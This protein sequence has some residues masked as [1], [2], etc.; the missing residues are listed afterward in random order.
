[1]GRQGLHALILHFGSIALLPNRR[2]TPLLDADESLLKH[3][4]FQRLLYPTSHVTER[5]RCQAGY[6]SAGA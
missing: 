1:M 6:V 2:F 5:R 3:V 4:K